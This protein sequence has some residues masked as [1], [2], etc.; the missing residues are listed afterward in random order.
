ME[1]NNHNQDIKKETDENKEI[2][3]KKESFCAVVVCLCYFIITLFN[4]YVFNV[5]CSWI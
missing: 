1:I 2:K 4:K 5:L 3:N